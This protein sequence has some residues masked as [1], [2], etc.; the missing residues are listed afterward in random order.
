MDWLPDEW[1][2]DDDEVFRHYA[3]MEALWIE[4]PPRYSLPR[5]NGNDDQA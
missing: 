2:E 1:T 5:Q 4:L 3:E